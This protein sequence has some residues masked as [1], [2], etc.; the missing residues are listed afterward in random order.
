MESRSEITA[1]ELNQA[2]GRILDRVQAGEEITVI[3]DGV[4]AAVIRRPGPLD[5][6]A[7]S[8]RTD[9]MGADPTWTSPPSFACDLPALSDEEINEALRGMGGDLDD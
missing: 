6:P 7:Y 8:F 5:P 2:S 1:R 9:P 4:A 3:R